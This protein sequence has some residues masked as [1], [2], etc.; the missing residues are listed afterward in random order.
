MEDL[1]IDALVNKENPLDLLYVPS[2]LVIID[3]NKNNFHNYSDPNMKPELSYRVYIPYKNMERA[4]IYDGLH[5]VVDSGYRSSNYQKGVFERFLS[6]YIK[7][8]K[9][10]FNDLDD[11]EIYLIAY[12]KTC[13]RVA[14]PG[15][16]EHQTGLAFDIGAMRNNVY[17][18]STNNDERNWMNEN[19]YKYGFILRYPKG[20]EDITG[21]NFEPW[22]YRYVGEDISYELY[23]NGDWITLE[24]YHEKKLKRKM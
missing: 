23:N 6:K 17:S 9:Q 19:A 21:F 8:T 16:S 14:L 15:C 2:D 7:E 3:N 13:E 20:K 4:S 22:H 18:S 5:I 12:K 10:L 24:E 1:R 11:N